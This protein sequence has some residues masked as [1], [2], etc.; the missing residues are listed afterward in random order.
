MLQS[1]LLEE[2]Y[3]RY[4]TELELS[5]GQRNDGHRILSDAKYEV[6]YQYTYIQLPLIFDL[7]FWLK[8]FSY[9]ADV[10]KWSK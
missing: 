10:T 8:C 9:S 6:C 3:Q 5:R 7:Y 1:Q 2:G 4:Q